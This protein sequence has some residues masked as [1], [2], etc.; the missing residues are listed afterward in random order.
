MIKENLLR[1][2]LAN[3]FKLTGIMDNGIKSR[4]VR[5]RSLVD[6][7]SRDVFNTARQMAIYAY[8]SNSLS[9]IAESLPKSPKNP[10][11]ATFIRHMRKGRPL[12][13][14]YIEK[15][16][17][18]ALSDIDR[19]TERIRG[20]HS[21]ALFYRGINT[22]LLLLSV[23]IINNESKLRIHNQEL[24]LYKA[25]TKVL[26]ERMHQSSAIGQERLAKIIFS[27]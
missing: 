26:A 22:F 18:A 17:Q 2:K 3:R 20:R 5:E 6:N 4:V 11:I 27:S 21:D 15:I 7:M 25:L 19:Y 24:K 9:Q 23:D 14:G 10:T 13:E 16:A 8:S 12:D 1:I